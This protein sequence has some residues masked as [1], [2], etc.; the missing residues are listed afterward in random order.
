LDSLGRPAGSARIAAVE[1]FGPHE[2]LRLALPDFSVLRTIAAETAAM[3]IWRFY[4][5]STA[6][7]GARESINSAE[8]VGTDRQT[9]ASLTIAAV[10]YHARCTE[11][12]CANLRRL[13]LRNGDTG[14]R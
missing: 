6:V 5:L 4:P 9:A 11:A 1:K 3:G 12:G 10:G 2:I 14:G 8:A 13:I 7:I